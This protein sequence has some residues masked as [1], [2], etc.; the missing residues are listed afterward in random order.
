MEE[1]STETSVIEVDGHATL[2]TK[3]YHIESNKDSN[4]IVQEAKGVFSREF[5]IRYEELIGRKLSRDGSDMWV[6]V[7]PKVWKKMKE[8]NEKEE[9]NDEETNSVKSCPHCESASF[10]LNHDKDMPDYL[11]RECEKRFDSP[12]ERENRSTSPH[13]RSGSAKKLLEANPEDVLGE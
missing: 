8:Q 13:G 12:K 10:Y 11:C 5:N 6:S 7:T 3:V 1:K 2:E 9:N 4:A